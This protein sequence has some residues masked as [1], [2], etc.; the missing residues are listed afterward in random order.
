MAATAPITMKYRFFPLLADIAVNFIL[1]WLIYTLCVDQTGEFM[2]L[3][4]SSA[5]PL[6]W[7]LVELAWH[8][9]VDALSMVVLGGILLSLLGMALGGDARLLL[10]RESLL[11][12]LVGLIFVLSLAL[13]LP[14][15]FH[16]ALAAQSRRDPAR[17]RARFLRWW[18]QQAG[19]QPLI[20]QL[21]LGWGLGLCGEALGRSYLA[22]VWPPER[23]LAVVPLCSYGFMGLMMAW[24]VWL[25]RRLG[26]PVTA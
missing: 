8:R 3:V 13:R 25:A 23:F 2:A 6:A 12:G 20:R 17:G 4:W 22:W 14:L 9:R 24:S 10:I 26:K 15:L 5:P 7:S 21:T 19:A 11:S 1:P 16:L 18:V